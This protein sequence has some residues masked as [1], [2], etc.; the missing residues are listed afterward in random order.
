MVVGVPHG[1]GEEAP[2]SSSSSLSSPTKL[3]PDASTSSRPGGHAAAAAADSSFLEEG[4]GGALAAEKTQTPAAAAPA[5][6]AA[7][8]EGDN[9]ARTVDEA[10][11]NSEAS[12]ETSGAPQKNTVEDKRLAPSCSS[13]HP[14]RESVVPIDTDFFFRDG[15]VQASPANSC[16]GAGENRAPANPVQPL[17]PTNANPRADAANSCGVCEEWRGGVAATPNCCKP[18][19]FGQLRQLKGKQ[20]EEIER[21]LIQRFQPERLQQMVIGRLEGKA[22]NGGSVED[23][24][25][26]PLSDLGTAVVR[27]GNECLISEG[28]R[29]DLLNHIRLSLGRTC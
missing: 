20:E 28:D 11:K 8:A 2:S 27:Y 18:A 16:G 19:F 23:V 17:P 15:E 14:L 22:T 6:T 1:A 12:A 29:I 9:D 5:T 24:L 21:L 7:S 10:T 13:E 3:A 26:K 25:A 4:V